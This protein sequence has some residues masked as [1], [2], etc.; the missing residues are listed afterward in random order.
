MR[1]E[2]DLA[3]IS[4][5]K[6]YEANDM[7][8]VDC[9][10]CQGCFSCCEGMGTSVILDPYDVRELTKGLSLTFEQLLN[11]VLELNVV[12]GLVLPNIKMAG[13]K[14]QCGFLNDEGRCAIHPFRPGFCRLF[15][16]GRIYADNRFWYFLQTKECRRQNR[17]KVKVKKWMGIP[18][19]SRY[20]WF[21]FAW[22][23]FLKKQQEQIKEEPDGE[24]ARMV[25][26]RLLKDF[27]LQPFADDRDFY[28]EFAARLLQYEG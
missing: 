10:G 26:M 11:S 23:K 25:C 8:R 3:E 22:H 14:E 24:W 7:V 16:L 2:I 4:D 20:E 17:G 9:G 13:E 1:R 12:D 21:V 27:Y 6:R 15:P 18:Q 28:E 5:G 19:F